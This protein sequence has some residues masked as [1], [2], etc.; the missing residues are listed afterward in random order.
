MNLKTI[1][2]ASAI[3]NIP[4]TTIREWLDNPDVRLEKYTNEKGIICVDLD[5][6]SRLETNVLTLYNKKGG[7]SKTTEAIML[8]YYYSMKKQKVLVIDFDS[9]ETIS[10]YFLGRNFVYNLKSLESNSFDNVLLK[11]DD[12]DKK[13]MLDN[14]EKDGKEY[15][16]KKEIS[17]ED[18]EV[19]IAILEEQE[20]DIP[21]NETLYDFF[22]NP[23]KQISK[24][25]KKVDENI[26]I[27]PARDSFDHFDKIKLPE[28]HDYIEPLRKFFS[29]YSVV[30][31]DCPP[32]LNNF[33][34]LGLML[35]DYIIV[36][37]M[38]TALIYEGTISML[39]GLFKLLNYCKY[40]KGWKILCT[41]ITKQNI[42]VQKKYMDAVKREAEGNVFE[43]YIP[44][45][46]VIENMPEEK[47]N[48]F[49]KY[50]H[51]NKI[52]EIREALD[53]LDEYIYKI[54]D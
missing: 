22:I 35:A 49:E 36:P 7:A 15:I 38:P 51:D 13:F 4:S 37:F 17:E 26:D 45:Y 48:I 46:V 5:Q 30:V 41:N 34:Q 11:L 40:L 28:F 10:K 44:K 39:E 21:L 32:A 16:L 24:I 31:I 8:A 25:C 54:K 3:K 50:Q 12:E 14:Y 33:S 1:N 53:E 47:N 52:S 18:K 27:L 20:F 9:Q 2:E 42:K 29:K 6:L 43:K 23:K 19:V